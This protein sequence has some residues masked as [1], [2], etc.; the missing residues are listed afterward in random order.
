MTKY[1]IPVMLIALFISCNQGPD[2]KKVKRKTAEL[3]R[4][5]PVK[6]PKQ[7]VLPLALG[8][9]APDFDLPGVDGYYHQLSDYSDAEVLLVVFTCNHCPTAQAYEERIKKLTT[10]YKS[11]NVQVVAIS[12]NSPLGLLYEELGYSDLGDTYEDMLVKN[13]DAEFNFP[14][15]Y[16]GDNQKVSL[17]YGPAATPHC[18]LFDKDRKLRYRGRIDASEKP[19]SAHAEDIRTAIDQ[20]LAGE[21]VAI[22]ETKTFGCSTKW[23]WKTEMKG[24]TDKEWTEKEVTLDEIEL[25]DIKGLV[26]NKSDKLRLINIWATWCAPCRIEYPEFVAMQRMYGARDF[27]FVSISADKLEKKDRALQFL[28]DKASSLQNFIAVDDDKYALI[29]SIDPNWN[30]A[31][32]YTLLLEPGG[33]IVYRHQGEVDFAELKRTIVEHELMGRVY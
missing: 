21:P 26:G 12:P 6:V 1:L 18:F 2:Q 33:N 3:F 22:P 27:E 14:Y 17:A 23:G 15:L 5:K 16:D 19:G 20:L 7:E 28:I 9:A 32:P 31:L 11:K 13:R 29:E 10:D 25:A 4:S 8:A 30:G 24:R